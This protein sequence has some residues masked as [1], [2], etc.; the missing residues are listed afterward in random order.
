MRRNYRDAL[1]FPTLVVLFLFTSG[2]GFTSSMINKVMPSEPAP[3]KRVMV[4]AFMDNADL[5]PGTAATLAAE[6]IKKL[7]NSPQLMLDPDPVETSRPASSKSPELGIVIPQD[8]IKEAVREGV[9]ALVTGVLNPVETYTEKRGFWPPWP[10]RNL[11]RVYEVSLVI[12]VVD[13]DTRTLL[14]SRLESEKTSFPLEEDRDLQG[15]E[16]HSAMLQEQL[17]EV[18]KRQAEGTRET[19]EQHPWTARI[20][21]VEDEAIRIDAGKTLGLSAGQRFKVLAEGER[22]QAQ[23]GRQLYLAGKQ[24]GTIELF[25]VREQHSLGRAVEGGPFA[26][27]QIVR[28]WP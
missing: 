8:L 22:I 21:A 15:K 14:Y 18:L 13:I 23:S 16:R 24:I 19:L 2:C 3:L 5:A 1:F 4:M 17:R 7:Q 12:N 6:F 11:H 9:H 27:G 28:Y 10:F 20:A 25:A 26:P